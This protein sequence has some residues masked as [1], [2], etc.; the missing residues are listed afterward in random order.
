MLPAIKILAF[1]TCISSL[2]DI[3]FSPNGAFISFPLLENG[4]GP[5]II[6]E[7][8]TASCSLLHII[9]FSFSFSSSAFSTPYVYTL[10]PS[11]A[12]ILA[13]FIILKS[14]PTTVKFVLIKSLFLIYFLLVYYILQIL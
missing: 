7:F 1:I 13:N 8:L 4:I 3:V 9:I 5:I 2:I 6:S 10:F 11:S 12:S 14:P